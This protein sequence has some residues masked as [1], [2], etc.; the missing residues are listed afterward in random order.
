MTKLNI[1]KEQYTSKRPEG[2]PQAI[3][4]DW[5]NTLVDT[6]DLIFDAINHVLNTFEKPLWTR[7][8]AIERI[9]ASAREGLPSLFGDQWENALHC[10]RDFYRAKHLDCLKPT[11]GAKALLD[12]LQKANIPL[13]IVSNKGGELLRKEVT[14]LGWDSYFLAIVGSKD[15]PHDKP[16]PDMAILALEKMT[17]SSSNNVWLIGDAPVD[18]ECAEALGCLPIPIGDHHKE[19]QN[20]PYAVSNCEDIRNWFINHQD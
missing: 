2:L 6:F 3:L 12:T 18:W 20:Y 4:F 8:Q 11:T 16:A 5:D 13:G 1:S 7:E 19:S 14:H 17:I 15:A 9:Q 10:Y